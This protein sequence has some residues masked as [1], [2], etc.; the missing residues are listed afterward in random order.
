MTRHPCRVGSGSHMNGL[1]S[2]AMRC[3]LRRTRT[4][5][6]EATSPGTVVNQK[7]CR[8]LVRPQPSATL[9]QLARMLIAVSGKPITSQNER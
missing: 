1:V 6:V 7:R 8:F 3:H 4:T 2:T 5:P 9:R